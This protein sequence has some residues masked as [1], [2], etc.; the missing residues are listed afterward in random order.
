MSTAR[1]NF[2]WPVLII[3]V[4]IIMLMISADVIPEAYGDL[5]IRS[6]PILLLMFGLN[7]LLAGRLRYANWLVFGLSIALVVVIARF[8]YAERSTQYR[9]DYQESWQD[10]VPEEVTGIVINIETKETRVT[11]S[12]APFGRQILTRF[13][14]STE[15]EVAIHMEIDGANA[16]FTVSESRSGIL[17]RLP[18]VGR[19]TLNVFLPAGV[20]IQ[21]LNYSGD[22]GS[23]T[24]DLSALTIRRLDLVVKRGN[25]RLCLPNPDVNGELLVGNQIGLNNG[26]L[27]LIVPAG[28]DLNLGLTN[29]KQQPVYEPRGKENDYVFLATGALETRGVVNNQFDI[30]LDI[31]VDGTFTLDHINRCQ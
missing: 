25:M 26:D 13:E 2:V 4:G 6:W 9:D 23:V 16:I 29:T 3:G 28:A 11:L 7:I 30:L 5:L 18:A 8:A 14:G 21:E 20:L 17:P 27:Q 24:A 31:A 15:S 1:T 12:H 19:G 22:D 10:F